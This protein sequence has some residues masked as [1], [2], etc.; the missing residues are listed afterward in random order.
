MVAPR[1]L[2]PVALARCINLL[3]EGRLAAANRTYDAVPPAQPAFAMDRL[4]AQAFLALNGSRT[5][6]ADEWPAMAANARRIAHLPTTW[7]VGRG[8]PLVGLCAIRARAADFDAGIVLADQARRLVIGRST[9]VTLVVDSLLGQIAMARGPWPRM[10]TF[11]DVLASELA[12]ER[13][14]SRTMSTP[15]AWPA[16]F[17]APAPCSCTT[18]PRRGWPS[19]SPPSAVTRTP[20]PPSSATWRNVRTVPA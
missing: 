6:P 8:T 14:A 19:T 12:L 17:T 20:R 13:T 15:G 2:G 11:L 5:V 7:Q 1:R 16:T 3:F 4:L 10:G 18:P 9:F